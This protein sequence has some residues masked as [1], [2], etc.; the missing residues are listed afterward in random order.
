HRHLPHAV[1]SAA[2]ARHPRVQVGLVLEEVEMPPCLVLGVM[3]RAL[4]LR[5]PR[6]RA[7]EAG[8]AGKVEVQVK[9]ARLGVELGPLDPPR[10]RESQRGG[11]Q[12]LLHLDDPPGTVTH[13][14]NTVD[15]DRLPRGPGAALP[16]Q[17]SEEPCTP[18]HRSTSEQPRPSEPTA[19]RSSPPPTPAA[20]NGSADAPNHPNCPPWPGSTHPTSTPDY[21]TTDQLGVQKTL[22]G[23]A[24]PDPLSPHQHR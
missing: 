21:R 8:A 17:A 14:D 3:D 18:P 7:H 24:A 2:H 1:L 4:L 19:P 10:C 6:L 5:A 16:T 15:P 22:T 11:E 20:P 9:P 13:R 23:S 12:L